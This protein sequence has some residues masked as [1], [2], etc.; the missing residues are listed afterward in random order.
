MTLQEYAQQLGFTQFGDS[1]IRYKDASGETVSPQ[2]LEQLQNDFNAFNQTDAQGRPIYGTEAYRPGTMSDAFGQGLFRV[3]TDTAG[4]Q[5]QPILDKM[6]ASIQYDPRFGYVIP[7]AA[8]DEW[9]RQF[10][11]PKGF[12]A[13][14]ENLAS[15]APIA[16]GSAVLGG[17]LFGTGPL[18]G[19][20]T[21]EGGPLFGN[22]GSLFGGAPIS[23]G[24]GGFGGGFGGGEGALTDAA[25]AAGG[26]NMFDWLTDDVWNGLMNTSD[27]LPAG[28]IFGAGTIDPSFWENAAS[29]LGGG[30][31]GTFE[32]S[33]DSP[34][35]SGGLNLANISRL[36][37]GGGSLLNSLG[38]RSAANRAAGIQ[39]GVAQQGIDEQRRQFDALVNLMSPFVN[40]GTSALGGQR[41]LLGLNGAAG[42]QSAIDA[43]QN[44]PQFNSLVSTGENAIRQNASATGGLRGGNIQAALAKFRP[45]IL[46]SLI[47][48]QFNRLG[49]ISQLG[50]A[51][52]AGQASAGLNTGSN[53]AN[54]LGQQG[55]ALAGGALAQRN[56]LGDILK[57]AGLVGSLF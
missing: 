22:V 40:A 43:I 19:A 42:Q 21:I 39:S 33:L 51:S 25:S 34:L 56:P 46:S 53:I 26:N 54:L 50:Q 49:G 31:G 20:S 52:A 17:G 11:Q 32:G 12:D 24:S 35:S 6:G 30:A 28:D 15:N 55:Q 8:Q 4:P 57:T 44:S 38:A 37:T 1:N 3:G 2:A 9:S 7:Q 23:G 18:A 48:Q 27:S 47:D 41:D 16:L 45:Q 29:G 13:F 5:L 36:L 14:M 10:G